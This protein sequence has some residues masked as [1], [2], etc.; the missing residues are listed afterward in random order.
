[1]LA[2][3]QSRYVDAVTQAAGYK[4]VE[5]RWRST[6]SIE[7][8]N[9]RE[10]QCSGNHK[11]IHI[12]HADGI[13]PR[14]AATVGVLS[15]NQYVWVLVVTHAHFDELIPKRV[16]VK[17]EA[18]VDVGNPRSVPVVEIADLTDDFVVTLSKRMTLP[19]VQS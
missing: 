6:F 19:G 13:I 14:K 2:P 7:V 11:C 15:V 5:K 9:V 17:T 16:S 8:E 3:F 10:A 12:R 4:I 18:L 1:M